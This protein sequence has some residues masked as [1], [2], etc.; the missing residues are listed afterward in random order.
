MTSNVSEL[1]E[2]LAEISGKEFNSKTVLEK[3]KW[4]TAPNSANKLLANTVLTRFQEKQPILHM[5][6]SA[7]ADSKFLR[8][9]Q[10]EFDDPDFV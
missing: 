5:F 4:T 1:E 7:P 6:N 2:D 10:E 9:V 3:P 8:D